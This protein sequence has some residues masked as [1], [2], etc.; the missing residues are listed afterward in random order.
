MDIGIVQP[1]LIY[2]RGAE[3]QVCKLGY[4]LNKMGHEVTIY[5]FEKSE[6]YAFDPLLEDI[7]IISLNKAWIKGPFYT[8]NLP[9]WLYLIKKLSNNLKNHD[10][11]NAHNHPAQWIARYTKIPTIWTCNEPFPYNLPK[12]R[13]KLYYLHKK[14]DE[15][16]SSDVSLT[17]SLSSMMNDF[18]K[19][20][21]PEAKIKMVYSGA[22]IERKVMHKDNDY[23]DVIFVGPITVP[24]RP[25]DILDAFILIKDKIPN[26]RIHFV[27]KIVNFIS[28]RLKN[29]M[30]EN[31]QLNGIDVIFY[32]SVPNT[33]LYELFD[34]ADISIYVPKYEPFG[35]FPLETILGGIPTI[36]SDQ[37]GCR[38]ILSDDS[39][40]VK[41]GD[42]NELSNKALDIY[43][44]LGKYKKIT[45]ENSKNIS[46]NYSWEA[47]SKRIG[48]IFENFLNEYQDYE[49]IE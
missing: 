13:D 48:K 8:Y 34:I 29:K 15:N 31:A 35:I 46:Q 30:I 17:F 12:N 1:E 6:K 42:V 43:N 22:E 19:K 11:L 45:L 47:Y 7:E 10:I 18:I 44:N 49:S 32:D 14:I 5:T 23:F 20:R 4:H 27:G 24:K 25:M 26:I 33:K 38:E 37:C 40:V 21:Y 39:P 16:L 9:R 28:Q 36:V 2:P 3:K 41:T